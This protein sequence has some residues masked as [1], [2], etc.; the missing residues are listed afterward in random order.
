MFSP[1]HYHLIDNTES[2]SILDNFHIT[3][4]NCH[5]PHNKVFIEESSFFSIVSKAL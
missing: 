5:Y 4:N 2:T 1:T 3:S